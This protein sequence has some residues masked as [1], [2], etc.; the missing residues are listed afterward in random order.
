M[1]P[2]YGECLHAACCVYRVL[3]LAFLI[4]SKAQ[5]QNCH[6]IKKAHGLQH[7]RSVVLLLRGIVMKSWPISRFY[8]QSD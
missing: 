6:D 2:T 3:S 8:N 4:D 1:S 5:L 7:L